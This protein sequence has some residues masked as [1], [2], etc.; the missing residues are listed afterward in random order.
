MLG[1][2]A[3]DDVVHQGRIQS[4]ASEEGVETVGKQVHRV[5]AVQGAVGFSLADGGAYGVDDDCFGHVGVLFGG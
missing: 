5:D 4:R 2:D 3:A 1:D